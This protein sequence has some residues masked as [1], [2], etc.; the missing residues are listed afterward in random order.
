MDN[1]LKNKIL[2]LYEDACIDKNLFNKS[3]LNELG[4]PVFVGEWLIDKQLKE[5]EW[6]EEVKER[7]V[8]F[9]KKY[10]PPK[11]EIEA[12]KNRLIDGESITLLDYVSPKVNL[13][14][15]EKYLEVSSLGNEKS[16][17]EEHVLEKYPR[18]LKGG[19]WG[20]AVFK[21]HTN[22]KG[23][24]EVWL[25][26]FAPL[27]AADV[28]IEEYIEKRKE[29]KLNEWIDL[30]INS[31][32][33]NPN[34][35]E[36]DNKK[37][38]LIT[39]ILPLVQKRL[40]IFELAPK[41]TGKS[42]IFGNFSR[43][44]RLIPGGSISPAVLFYNEAI[45]QPGLFT[46]FDT[47]IFDECQSL[48]FSNPSQTVGMLKNYLEAGKYTK[49]KYETRADSGAVFLANVPIGENGLPLQGKNLFGQLPELLQETA[50]IDRI[51]GILPG[52][53]LPRIQTNTISDSVGF[54][55]DYIGEIFHILRNQP[56]FDQYVEDRSDLIITKDVRDKKAIIR[57]ATAFLKLLF[58]NL[59]KVIDQEY[60]DY[61]LKPAI[62]LRQRVRD[63]LHYL[64][65]EYQSYVI[66]IKQE[67]DAIV[68]KTDQDESN[69]IISIK[70]KYIEIKEG[71]TG[72]SYE[73]LFKPFLKNAR[74]IL[75]ID[76]FIRLNYQIDN[77]LSFC[78]IFKKSSKS[79]KF[80]LIT[81][82]SEENQKKMN[83]KIFK[84]ISE[85][86]EIQNIKFTYE[87]NNKEHDRKIETDNGWIINLGRG[88]DIFLK[89]DS[90]YGMDKLDYTQRKC[91]ATNIS[92]LKT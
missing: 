51:H 70:T 39:R 50:F 40:N 35:Y 76:P 26:K 12:L 71:K 58:P 64:D 5:D 82:Y 37:L 77:L 48:S 67:D 54:K 22:I 91:R 11:S 60:I 81:G 86:L 27:Q 31:I 28:E 75:L 24:G 36:T 1:T 21:Y 41:G 8:T 49:G 65:P 25:T 87:F 88:L 20:A 33:L 30:L 19:L 6:N 42:F 80:H 55:A 32:G 83:S 18:L 3:S 72:Y 14:K 16:F 45:K 23:Q 68:A 17:I 57:M 90:W 59:N 34:A 89:P 73:I 79:I 4:I 53:I 10:M 74:E 66:D 46:Q 2:S 15:N 43:Y 44:S 52:W 69:S 78:Q 56:Q 13:R 61:C 62:E 7:I 63:Q 29:I 9:I 38:A 92:Y 47:I 84:E 85:N